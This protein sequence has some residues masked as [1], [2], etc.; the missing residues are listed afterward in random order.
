[1]ILGGDANVL[2]ARPVAATP[3]T[4]ELAG[5]QIEPA[6]LVT[7]DHLVLLA[8]SPDYPGIYDYAEVVPWTDWLSDTVPDPLGM[9]PFALGL[10]TPSDFFNVADVANVATELVHQATPDTT[11][12]ETGAVTLRCVLEVDELGTGIS[13]KLARCG[14]VDDPALAADNDLYS[15]ELT[16]PDTIRAGHESGTDTQHHADWELLGPL[17]EDIYDITA[18]RDASGDWRVYLDG[19][20]LHYVASTTGGAEAA[21]VFSPLAG[22]ANGGDAVFGV[23]RYDQT[24]TNQ[25]RPHLVEAISGARTDAEA[26]SAVLR[27][28]DARV[29]AWA[30]TDTALEDELHDATHDIFFVLADPDDPEGLR[31]V[32]G[33]YDGDWTEKPGEVAARIN[34]ASYGNDSRGNGWVL[35]N[36]DTANW[37][38][39]ADYVWR[40]Y[41]VWGEGDSLTATR[42][43]MSIHTISGG[44][45]DNICNLVVFSSNSKVR[46][47]Q[48][49]GSKTPEYLD[50]GLPFSVK[51]GDPL[52]LTIAMEDQG[53]GTHDVRA[54]LNGE[55]CTIDAVFE[56]VTDNGDDSA[57]VIDGE[58]NSAN[59][60]LTLGGVDYADGSD[61]WWRGFQ[62]SAGTTDTATESAHAE[63]LFGA[64]GR[65]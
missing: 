16:E 44:P 7:P 48:Q 30:L 27:G 5:Q 13:Y 65:L 38:G 34:G 6:S 56:D 20:R 49:H 22:A 40:L 4:F 42:R 21:G 52:L 51:D 35:D 62:L 11:I 14:G 9:W 8:P 43:M 18:T 31:Q 57:N 17:R 54:W 12:R 59:Q 53:D 23:E 25:N 26:Q 50:F 36:Q 41:W 32:V 3:Y 33:D 2:G 46:W 61:S 58:P 60:V 37:A 45:S 1:M 63:A 15:L 28:G 47:F 64:T 29:D 55:V 19:Y 24:S 10:G 39:G